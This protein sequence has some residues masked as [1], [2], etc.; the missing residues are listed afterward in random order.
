MRLVRL[1]PGVVRSVLSK[2]SAYRATARGKNESFDMDSDP[3]KLNPATVVTILDIN[4]K[5]G[6]SN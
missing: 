3:T 2:P 6:T 4:G 1:L 5:F